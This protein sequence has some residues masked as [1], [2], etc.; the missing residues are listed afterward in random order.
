[1]DKMAV[2]FLC[3]IPANEEKSLH[4]MQAAFNR[5]PRRN[6]QIRPPII[7]P[8]NSD[9]SQPDEVCTPKAPKEMKKAKATDVF[10]NTDQ[11][12]GEACFLFFARLH[13]PDKGARGDSPS[14]VHAKKRPVGARGDSQP[15]VH[16]KKRPVGARGDS[17]PATISTFNIPSPVLLSETDE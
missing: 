13:N 3:G 6:K 2:A 9:G 5:N 14:A 16:A 8:D 11:M 1:M 7:D 12:D 4:L 10:T 17:P 15:A